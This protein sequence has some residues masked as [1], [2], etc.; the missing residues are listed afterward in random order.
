MKNQ[1]ELIRRIIA[2]FFLLFIVE[3]GKHIQVPFFISEKIPEEST[4]L[5][6]KFLATSTGG[7]FTVPT[8]FSLG[9]GP[10]MTALIIWTTISMIDTESI[11]N[12]STKRIGYIQRSL[13]LLFAILQSCA[14]VL[15]FRSSMIDQKAIGGSI[16]LLFLGAV[17][18]L[19]AGG[20]FVAWLADINIDKGIGGQSLFIV[21]GL[22]MNIPA[23][24]ISGQ[25]ESVH[26]SQ[27]FII[28]LVMVTLVFIYLTL[29]LYN[30]E[31]R[32]NIERTGIDSRFNNSYIPIRLLPA[33]AMPFMFAVTVFSMPQLLLLNEKWGD[34]GFSNFI[35][36]YFS[37][38]NVRGIFTYGLILYVLGYGFSFINVRP[39]DIA[40]N[41]KETGDYILNV[42]P[43][44][45]TERYILK[46]LSTVALLGNSYLVIVSMI[47]LLIGLQ[48]QI[49]SNL[50][51][52]FGSIFMLIII[53]ETITNE[54]RFL[55][56]R[57]TYRIF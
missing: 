19:T 10:Y 57:H 51:F 56:S 25:T 2:S 18:L 38:N 8:L 54:I 42:A 30:A 12:L 46:R 13:T 23:M 31:Y 49:I 16:V 28:G 15:K 52:Y 3:I 40:K 7:N 4:S 21:P 43:G 26:L 9:M 14:L 48:N 24:L 47:P 55:F 27:N 44:K 37:F 41:L 11:G 34:T 53:L 35:T 39:Y 5:I 29:F 32:I 17:L 36:T 1:K 45:Q 22:L 20:L 50:A 6:L 33:G